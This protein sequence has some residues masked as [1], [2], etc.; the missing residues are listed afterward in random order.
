MVLC[1]TLKPLLSLYNVYIWFPPDLK[2][3]PAAKNKKLAAPQ[4]LLS[5]IK[6]SF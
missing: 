5:Y 2:K 6:F 4:V 3:S 1:V